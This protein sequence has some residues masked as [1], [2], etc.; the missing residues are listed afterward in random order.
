MPRSATWP[1]RAPRHAEHRFAFLLLLYLYF[2]RLGEGEFK[3]DIDALALRSIMPAPAG[4]TS[5]AAWRDARQGRR[6][7]F[8]TIADFL[9]SKNLKHAFISFHLD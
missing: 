1:G 5:A 6:L 2:V 4:F 9:P 8:E 3:D 7:L